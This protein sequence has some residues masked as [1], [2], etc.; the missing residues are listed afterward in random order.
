M[1][2]PSVKGERPT[3]AGPHPVQKRPSALR[4]VTG[5]GEGTRVAPRGVTTKSSDGGEALRSRVVAVQRSAPVR[6]LRVAWR[7]LASLASCR[8]IGSLVLGRVYLGRGSRQQQQVTAG[9]SDVVRAGW[10]GE[11]RGRHKL[12]EIRLRCGGG[13]GGLHRAFADISISRRKRDWGLI[14]ALERSHGLW[15]KPKGGNRCGRNGDE[16]QFGRHE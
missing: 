6:A 9:N 11:V 2:E 5:R 15:S 16:G 13:Y 3:C 1:L 12:C 7:R 10:S 14:A 8:W 4:L